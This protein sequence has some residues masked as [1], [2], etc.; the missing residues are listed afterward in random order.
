MLVVVVVVVAAV[1]VAVAVAVPTQEQVCVGGAII[2][3][4]R[5]HARNANSLQL[6]I[7]LSEDQASL[8]PTR[9]SRQHVAATTSGRRVLNLGSFTTFGF[10]A[11]IYIHIYI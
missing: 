11:H 9:A 4:L 10:G 6:L 1:A 2:V 5:G 7:W 3:E 8:A